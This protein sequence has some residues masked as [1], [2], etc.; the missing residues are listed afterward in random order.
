VSFK[1]CKDCVAEGGG[2]KRPTVPGVP[3]PRCATHHRIKLAQRRARAAERRVEAAFKMSSALYDALYEA[4][5][6]TCW[7]CRISTGKRKRLAV[8]HDHKCTTG[9]D[10]KLGCPQCW[11][12]LLC[13]R[14]NQLVAWFSPEQLLR[15]IQYLANP[16]A[17]RILEVIR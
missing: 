3:G 13:G 8:D 7:I 10:P 11:R 1:P 17:R 12:G 14:C 15:A 9:H 5:G 4:Q 6:G 16:P 2:F